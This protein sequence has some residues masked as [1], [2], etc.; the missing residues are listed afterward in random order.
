M[1]EKRGNGRR[2]KGRRRKEEA[3]DA[4]WPML[5]QLKQFPEKHGH[6]GVRMDQQDLVL[7]LQ[8][9]SCFLEP[10]QMCVNC[11]VVFLLQL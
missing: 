10:H 6:M 1:E 9:L 4:K 3:D 11:V 8:L 5:E 7:T 2:R